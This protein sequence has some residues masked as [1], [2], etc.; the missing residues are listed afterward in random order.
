MELELKTR[1]IRR[2]S[3]FVPKFS[4]AGRHSVLLDSKP[5]KP[6][7]EIPPGLKFPR[8]H[9]QEIGEQCLRQGA[10]GR[11]LLFLT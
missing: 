5:Q 3:P 1:S 2:Q 11:T 9:M 7:A 4:S 8:G 10:L 6:L